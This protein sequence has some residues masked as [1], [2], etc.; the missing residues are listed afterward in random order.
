MT[1]LLII[2]S[3]L[4]GLTLG[5]FFNVVALRVPKGESI[6]YPPSHCPH[7]RKQLGVRDLVPVLSFLISRGRCRHCG[8]PISPLYLLGELS[9]GLLFAAIYLVYGFS[10]EAVVAAALAGLSVIITISDLAY[11]LIPNKV[12]LFFLPLFAFLRLFI[13]EESYW[14]YLL[15]MVLAGGILLSAALIS[16]RGMG[17]G[18]VKLFALY[19]LALGPLSAFLAL[20]LASLAGALVGGTLILRGKMKRKDPIPFGPFLALGAMLAELFGDAIF[21]F[22]FS[23]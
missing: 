16:R 3:L 8:A 4:F 20:F 7:C 21:S 19:G 15:G 1:F 14:T 6:L 17:M 11:L 23:L 22:Y 12:L 9:T 13:R 18:D 5:S 10:P 2:F